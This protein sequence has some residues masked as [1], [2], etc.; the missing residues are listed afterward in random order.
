M[1]ATTFLAD[2]NGLTPSGEA[3]L[4]RLRATSGE[5]KHRS[6][7]LA[8][9]KLHLPGPDKL[10]W[11]SHRNDAYPYTGRKGKADVEGVLGR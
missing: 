7:S 2:C 3:L 10:L 9:G 5:S 1:H 4:E 8:G 11:A 6:C